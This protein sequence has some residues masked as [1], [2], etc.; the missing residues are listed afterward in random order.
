MSCAAL[1]ILLREL[2]CLNI[3]QIPVIIESIIK[4]LID[5]TGAASAPGSNTNGLSSGVI[6]I[7][8]LLPQLLMHI[9]GCNRMPSCDNL[10]E[11]TVIDGMSGEE[12]KDHILAKLCKLKWPTDAAMQFITILKEIKMNDQRQQI[13]AE[14]ILAILPQVDL[15]MLPGLVYQVLLF[16]GRS[17]A[18]Q[19]DFLNG[20]MTYLQKIE[21]LAALADEN[22]IRAANVDTTSLKIAQA[23]I[24]THFNFVVKQ[25]HQIGTT[26]MKEMKK[27][28]T[29]GTRTLGGFT[30]ALLLSIGSIQRFE[31][32]VHDLLKDY[33]LSS[34]KDSS[35]VAHQQTASAFLFSCSQEELAHKSRKNSSATGTAPSASLHSV[36]DGATIQDTLLQIV[37][38]IKFGW[39]HILQCLVK[40]CMILMDSSPSSSNHKKNTK[41]MSHCGAADF[42]VRLLAEIFQRYQSVQCFVLEYA[43]SV[44]VSNAH[45]AE[46]YVTLLHKLSP[47][48]IANTPQQLDRLKHSLEYL[49][50]LPPAIAHNF[51]EACQPIWQCRPELRD[52]VILILRKAILS[53]EEASRIIAVN[54]LLFL[55]ADKSLFSRASSAR[56]FLHSSSA[57]LSNA[58]AHIWSQSQSSVIMSQQSQSQRVSN[59]SGNTSD[60]D[61][62][63]EIAGYFKRA[64]RQQPSVRTALYLGIENLFDIRLDLRPSLLDLMWTHFVPFIQSNEAI[65]PPL[66]ISDKCFSNVTNFSCS[67]WI[68][69][70][71]YLVNTILKL[72][73]TMQQQEN[74]TENNN[75]SVNVACRYSIQDIQHQLSILL[76]RLKRTEMEDYELDKASHF[77]PQTPMGQRNHQ[78]AKIIIGLNQALMNHLL[79]SKSFCIATTNQIMLDVHSAQAIL[80]AFNMIEQLQHWILNGDSK[81]N[82]SENKKGSK[83]VEE[84]SPDQA[85]SESSS[86]SSANTTSSTTGTTKRMDEITTKNPILSADFLLKMMQHLFNRQTTAIATSQ[87]DDDD[88]EV[89]G[90]QNGSSS[91]LLQSNEDFQRFILLHCTT[92]MDVINDPTMFAISGERLH[93]TYELAP[94]RFVLSLGSTLMFAFEYYL[95]KQAQSITRVLSKKSSLGAENAKKPSSSLLFLV[96]QL[97]YKSLSRWSGSQSR[98][99]DYL[100]S[101]V[102]T[103]PVD[104]TATVTTED[105]RPSDDI[106]LSTIVKF[107]ELFDKLCASE[108]W[109][110][111]ELILLILNLLISN[112]HTTSVGATVVVPETSVHWITRVVKHTSFPNAQKELTLGVLKML[113]KFS[114]ASSVQMPHC[115]SFSLAIR[116]LYDVDQDEEQDLE[117]H[118]FTI[119]ETERGLESTLSILFAEFE[120]A[121]GETS[122]V[123]KQVQSQSNAWYKRCATTP[124]TDQPND[125]HEYDDERVMLRLQL[126]LFARLETILVSISPLLERVYNYAQ[127]AILIHVL[128]RWYQQLSKIIKLQHGLPKTVTCTRR[129]LPAE[130]KKLLD[131]G[132]K[133]VAQQI[134]TYISNQSAHNNLEMANLTVKQQQQKKRKA[135]SADKPLK[136]STISVS[137]KRYARLVPELIYQLEQFD[138]TV[139]K[140]SKRCPNMNFA[141]WGKR[142]QARDFRINT[143]QM[144]QHI[145]E[146]L[147]LEEEEEEEEEE[148][149]GSDDQ[150][151]RTQ[152]NRHKSARRH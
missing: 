102:I 128:V 118:R 87:E 27:K 120:L 70:L 74:V 134:L 21:N 56:N 108:C 32:N 23:N 39:D 100:H 17:H 131:L 58:S 62:F 93:P 66:H 101:L 71:P 28:M 109:S 77:S 13:I 44:I 14:K 64:I 117:H 140:L 22:E 76:E 148:E 4:V 15:N 145:Q 73:R 78:M 75:G 6:T 16:A 91:N 53:R 121:L 136:K 125:A 69:N 139:I 104:S 54:G 94:S 132:A 82:G 9:E 114:R 33:V 112:Y 146:Q 35:R 2:D 152:N 60:S 31:S 8:E 12:Y 123:L 5:A 36:L 47:K 113:M 18:C 68:E 126:Q 81:T 122:L 67:E 34:M 84:S 24:L 151:N 135:K 116:S 11:A 92:F 106:L 80:N 63:W 95:S 97:L 72:H 89:T 105:Q 103:P 137:A 98:L 149:V 51:I 141:S 129:L 65:L 50:F 107:Q 59:N 3:K 1:R 83:K 111:C 124:W 42:G 43:L 127:A 45:V 88:D 96:L 26:F 85:G 150:E 46:R 49:S 29:S 30:I 79:L 133:E 7:T 41:T 110:E 130:L 57:M 86:S 19:V 25:D 143:E 48:A 61:L 10:I 38:N 55:V 20:L 40:F 99:N 142:R 138:M 52:H 119:L 144:Q 90:S 115:R 147:L 37:L